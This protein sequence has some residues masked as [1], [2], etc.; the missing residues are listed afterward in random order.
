MKYALAIVVII[1]AIAAGFGACWLFWVRPIEAV[2][3]K[4]AAEISKLEGEIDSLAAQ[5]EEQIREKIREMDP[6]DVVSLYLD[7][8][9][10]ERIRSDVPDEA[11]RILVIFAEF[12]ASVEASRREDP[13]G[14]P[15]EGG[16]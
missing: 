12:L 13:P 5:K 4:A 8:E 1:L 7:A 10:V 16:R 2:H 6:V 3:D 14:G 15:G 9:T 11:Q